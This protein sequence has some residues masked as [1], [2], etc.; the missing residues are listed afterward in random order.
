MGQ[1]SQKESK[2]FSKMQKPPQSSTFQKTD[3][4]QVQY[5]E[6]S[7]LEWPVNLTIIWRFLLHACETLFIYLFF[8][9]RKK[10]QW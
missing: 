9:V 8:Y 6:P 2:N 4:K 5:K 10:L 1:N 7:I 3:M